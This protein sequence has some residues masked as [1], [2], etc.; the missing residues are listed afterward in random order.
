MTITLEWLT[1][2]FYHGLYANLF[3]SLHT[4]T[5]IHFTYSVYVVLQEVCYKVEE[6]QCPPLVVSVMPSLPR[7][8]AVELHVIAVQDEPAERTSCQMTSEISGASIHWQVLQSSTR[9]YATLSLNVS[10]HESCTT[11]ECM[12]TEGILGAVS[13]S[14]QQALEQMEETLSPL[15]TRIFYKDS[16]KLATE[17][18]AGKHAWVYLNQHFKC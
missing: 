5:H 17:L 15:C 6:I 14:F 18:S 3:L 9:L 4:R 13:T 7:G 16:N 11:P 8:A 12:D 1:Y 2:W 10:L